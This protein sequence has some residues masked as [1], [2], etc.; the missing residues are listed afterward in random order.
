MRDR[1]VVL[2]L[3]LTFFL[4]PLGLFYASV[5]GALALIGLAAIGVV[6]TLGFVLIFVWP[7]SMAWAAIAASGKH[8]AFRQ[9]SQHAPAV[10][11]G[12]S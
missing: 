11:A 10:G 1:S 4:G 5:P 8:M 6:P 2:A 9:Q 12:L 3:A 7:A